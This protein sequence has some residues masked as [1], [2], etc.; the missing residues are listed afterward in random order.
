MFR[1]DSNNI[2]I[3]IVAALL[4]FLPVLLT[5][6]SQ[7]PKPIHL[8][9]DECAHCRM[10][11]TDERFASQ[12]VNE[13]GKATKFDA[14]ECMALY[15]EANEDEFADARLWVGDFGNPG[16]WLGVD[17]AVFIKSEVIQSPM[18]A[19]LL[20]LPSEEAAEKHL[21]EYPGRKLTWEEVV[22][23]TA[24]GSNGMNQEASVN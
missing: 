15:Y 12:I 6:C 9:S 17:D 22:G 1:S 23:I 13:N 20:A 18:G 8:N 21:N 2:P 14:I 19:S 16:S 5:G 3:P 11:I 7:D 10:M 24:G 4:V